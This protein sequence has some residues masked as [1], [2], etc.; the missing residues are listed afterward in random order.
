MPWPVS[1]NRPSVAQ[2]ASTSD[3]NRGSLAAPD[4]LPGIAEMSTVGGAI[5]AGGVMAA[6]PA[7]SGV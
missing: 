7:A 1:T 6:L 2:A 4:P 5:A 3:T